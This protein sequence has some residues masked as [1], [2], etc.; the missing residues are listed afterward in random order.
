[1]AQGLVLPFGIA[2]QV[3]KRCLVQGR[4]TVAFTYYTSSIR[5]SI[6]PLIFGSQK[7]TAILNL[8]YECLSCERARADEAH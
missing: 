6:D 1:M 5:S 2:E 8:L 3:E 7:L 4:G